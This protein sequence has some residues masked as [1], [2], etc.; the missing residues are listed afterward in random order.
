MKRS[1]SFIFAI[2]ERIL[3]RDCLR[4]TTAPHDPETGNQHRIACRFRHRRQGKGIVAAGHAGRR[5][6]DIDPDWI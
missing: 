1:R 4:R 2:Y 5:P 6:K 3:L